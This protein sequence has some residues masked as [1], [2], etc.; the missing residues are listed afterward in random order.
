MNHAEQDDPEQDDGLGPLSPPPSAE[1]GFST[2]RTV[3]TGD[4]D[5]RRRLRLDS[6]ARYLQDVAGDDLEFTGHARTDPYW[7]VRRTVIDV[8]EPITWPATVHLHRWCSGLST[9]WAN[10]R[11]RLTADPQAGPDDA[12]T[13][14][15]GLVETEAFWINVNAEGVPARISNEGFATLSASTQDH[16]LRW[17][18]MTEPLPTEAPGRDLPVDRPH[19]LRSTDF[20]LLQHLNNAAYLDAV[21]DEL[22]DHQDLL[23]GR[24]RI[25]I[26]YSRPVVPGAVMT[27]RRIRSGDRLRMWMLVEDRVAAAV[28]VTGRPDARQ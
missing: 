22:L 23:R 16:R 14:P 24:H 13:R 1:S 9:R 27:I 19:V 17:A 26:E 10:M 28:T 21:E 2:S 18:A 25:V 12:G 7:I 4:V 15:D 5:P 6:I 3:R 20:D 11:V 8:I